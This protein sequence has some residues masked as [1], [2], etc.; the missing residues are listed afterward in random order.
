[1]IFSADTNTIIDNMG[2]IDGGSLWIFRL[3]T[4]SEERLRI[5]GAKYLHL[6]QGIGG[7]FRIIHHESTDKAVSVRH[8][9][10][11]AIEIASIAFDGDKARFSG[12]IT[13]WKHVKSACVFNHAKGQQ[14][15]YI[16]PAAMAVRAL[17]RSWFTNDNY[18]LGYQGLVDC[19]TFP[20]LGSALVSI[21]RSSEL[22]VIDLARN[23]RV[24]SIMLENRGGNPHI[25]I[26]Q[27]TEFIATDYDT[28][29]RV[30]AGTGAV[31]KSLRL[32][33]GQLDHPNSQLFI[34][35]YCVTEAGCAVARP[36]SGDVMLLDPVTFARLGAAK[37]GGQPLSVCLISATQVV[38][39]DWKTGAP[40]IGT[41]RVGNLELL[42]GFFARLS[43]LWSRR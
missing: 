40:K 22:V 15:L 17:D 37:M 39:R 36:F 19:V 30:D 14:L 18:D 9:S 42:R 24:G 5:P 20:S 7:Y 11:P 33:V 4:R 29:C 32:Q 31:M 35:D 23:K 41:I 1:M 8:I 25:Q 34:G 6:R 3:Q 2:W 21:Q 43:A 16:D 26:L 13:A 27:N 10:D 38:T 12:D 28:I